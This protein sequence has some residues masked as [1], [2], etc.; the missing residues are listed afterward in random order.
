[1]TLTFD[2]KQHPRSGDGK[3]SEKTHSEASGVS[4]PTPKDLTRRVKIATQVEIGKYNG[5]VPVFPDGLPEPKVD[6]QVSDSGTF[7]TSFEFEHEGEKHTYL[8][9][10]DSFGDWTHDIDEDSQWGNPWVFDDM[11]EDSFLNWAQATAERLEANHDNVS[12]AA[13]NDPAIHTAIIE[14]AL[15]TPEDFSDRDDL[16]KISANAEGRADQ[17]LRI[18]TDY[19]SN[20]PDT[21]LSDALADLRHWADARGIDFDAVVDRSQRSYS[22][23]LEE[24]EAAIKWEAEH[25]GE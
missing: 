25:P 18:W 12:F 6:Y 19:D 11:D 5:S 16:T 1:M 10:T 7:E 4:L 14:N 8:V 2:E 13:A 22:Y 23:E 3:F 15:G 17:V 21:V 24:Q 20:E 9:W